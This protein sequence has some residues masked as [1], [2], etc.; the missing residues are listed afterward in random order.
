MI[1]YIVLFLQNLSVWDEQRLDAIR[2]SLE[3]HQDK[4]ILLLLATAEAAFC[5]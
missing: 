5:N 3:Q 2:E 4:E 1:N